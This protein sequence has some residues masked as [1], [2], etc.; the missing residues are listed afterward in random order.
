MDEHSHIRR[1]PLDIVTA[2]SKAW[3]QGI[4]VARDLKQTHLDER[5][6]LLKLGWPVGHALCEDLDKGAEKWA[7]I[8]ANMRR[9]YRQ[10]IEENQ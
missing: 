5:I 4:Q 3:Q 1:K 7:A 9:D 6:L 8:E 2:E 10:H